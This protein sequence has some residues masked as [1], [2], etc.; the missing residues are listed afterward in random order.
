MEQRILQPG[1]IESLDRITHP[2]IIAPNPRTL[3]ADRARRLDQLAEGN[4]IADYLRFAAHIARAQH[5]AAADLQLSALDPAI[6]A[7][8]QEHSLPLAPA[9]D[10]MDPAWHDV[11]D[12]MLAKLGAADGLPA[13][14]APLVQEL[15]KLDRDERDRIARTL[16]ERDLATRHIGFAPFIMAA[17]QVMFTARAA[18]FAERDVPYVDPATICPICASEPVASVQYAGG[19]AAGH[20]YLSCASCA[21]QWHLVRVQCTHCQSTGSIQYQGIEGAGEGK[22]AAPAI[23]AETCGN[24]KT[25]RKIIDLDKAPEAEPLADDLAS[26]MLDL[27][28]GETEFSRASPNPLLYVA[29]AEPVEEGDAPD[30]PLIEPS[31]KLH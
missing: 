4:P 25:Y 2:R 16:L 29:I 27:L 15:A 23:Q 9:L 21:T 19:P 28:M 26:L 22:N 20:R 7:R 1:E 18:Q 8:A 31:A 24:C 13:P 12:A 11:L 6:I 17:L 14:L 3:F 30:A 10:N 5:A